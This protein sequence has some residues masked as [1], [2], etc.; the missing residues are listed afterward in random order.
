MLTE[1]EGTIDSTG[2][3]LFQ[4]SPTTGDRLPKRTANLVPF[5]AILEADLASEIEREWRAGGRFR[6]LQ[7]LEELAVSLG[8]QWD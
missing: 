6:A 1:Y 3:C 8:T 5:W 7:M 2:I 4:Q